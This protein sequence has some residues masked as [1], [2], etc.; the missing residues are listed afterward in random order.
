[1]KNKKILVILF[2][3]SLNSI[4]PSPDSSENPFLQKK[5]VANSGKKLQS[6]KF[7]YFSK[8]VFLLP[9]QLT[10]QQQIIVQVFECE[11]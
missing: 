10:I 1:M 5:I 11:M 9:N 4:N 2:K 8:I 6:I 3:I 7:L